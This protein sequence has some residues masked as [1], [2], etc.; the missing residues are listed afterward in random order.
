MAK[1]ATDDVVVIYAL[2]CVCQAFSETAA[3]PGDEPAA[4]FQTYA[5]WSFP[6]SEAHKVHPGAISKIITYHFP[7]LW[8]L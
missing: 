1:S 8:V 3:L 5:L 2:Q 6:G 4:I 7:S